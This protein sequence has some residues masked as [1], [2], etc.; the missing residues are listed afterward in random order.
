MPEQKKF[1]IIIYF[2]IAL[3]SGAGYYLCAKRLF[4]EPVE[5]AHVR[6]K[7]QTGAEPIRKAFFS[8]DNEIRDILIGLIA[9][10]KER[11]MIAIFSFTDSAIAQALI[12]AH[13]RGVLI[14]IVADRTN[15]Q[16]AWSKIRLLGKH[17]IPLYLYP[18]DITYAIMHD[19]FILFSKTIDEK[20]LVWTG[21]Y[22][23]TRSASDINEEN[24]MIIED[25][26]L[27]AAYHQQFK[28]LKERSTLTDPALIK[29]NK[30][31]LL[32]QRGCT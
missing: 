4:A 25:A 14:E 2:C 26:G 9:A 17:E 16:S 20:Q 1:K 30:K 5:V 3:C 11:I 15:A 28:R 31:E 21:S 13:K 18:A 8:P 7:L 10:E 22:N 19:K 12:K 29:I 24:V 6:G 27:Y 32:K 23:F